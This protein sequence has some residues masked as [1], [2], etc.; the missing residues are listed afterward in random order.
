[1]NL[2]IRIFLLSEIN[3]ENNILQKLVYVI[4][5]NSNTRSIYINVE[6]EAKYFLL[7]R[8]PNF[9]SKQRIKIYI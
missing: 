1:M 2:F 5:K 8:R 7:K 6:S 4:T 3:E 9:M